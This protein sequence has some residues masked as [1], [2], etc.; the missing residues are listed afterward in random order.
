MKTFNACSLCLL[1]VL[2][3]AG[4]C[5][6][7]SSDTGSGT[8]GALLTVDV[9][10]EY[11]VKR[12][13]LQDIADVEYIPMETSD[14]FLWA[15]GNN[16]ITGDYILNANTAK[17]DITI[18]D[19]Q[20]KGI[21]SFNRQGG[22]REEYGLYSHVMFDDDNKHIF[23]YDVNK[24]GKIFTYD[25]N[26][27]FVR[28]IDRAEGKA[29]NTTVSYDANTFL[30]YNYSFNNDTTSRSFLFISKETGE[31]LGECNLTVPTEKVISTAI[32]YEVEGGMGRTAFIPI[33][34]TPA[35]NGLILA[36]LSNDTIF[37]M[38]AAK[39]LRPLYIQTPSRAA[40]DPEIFL[41]V[42]KET[43]DYIFFYTVEK[44]YDPKK[45]T[46]FPRKVIAYDK[47][48]KVFYT[49]EIYNDD[50]NN[51]SQK[52]ILST[53]ISPHNSLNVDMQILNAFDLIE[54]LENDELKGELKEVAAKLDEEDNP[55]VMVVNYR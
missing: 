1:G 24:T 27:E 31:I 21:K 17:G 22:G 54:S 35:G 39:E 15:G 50:I 47:K 5:S 29:Y 12:I 16:L 48:E 51:E 38:N 3:C 2:L 53:L 36:E 6:T 10:K 14:E 42:L 34:I 18:Y 4:S 19:R 7:K 9:E 11:P 26:G 13:K 40:M 55:V 23:V 33:P 41:Y 37:F 46:G 20:G 45:N 8:D 28:V 44:T 52:Y 49:P 25:M 32:K 43:K 30:T